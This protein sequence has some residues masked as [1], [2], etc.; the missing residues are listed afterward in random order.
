MSFVSIPRPRRSPLP[1]Q[2]L[3][4]LIGGL[5]LFLMA[6]SLITGGYQLLYAGKVFPGITMAGL[7][8]TNMTP[9]QASSVLSQRLTYPTGGR[10]VFRYQDRVWVATPTE[11]GVVLDTGTSIQRA[12]NV[13]RQG[14]LFNELIS[15]LNAWQGGL[16]LKPVIVFDERVAHGYL[17]NIATQ[18]NQP[19]VETDLHLDGTEVVYT[20]G[21]TGLLLDVDATLASLLPQLSAF[22]DGEVQ[23]AVME[24]SPLVMNAIAPAETLRRI[25]SAP[26]ILNVPDAQPGDPGPWTIDPPHLA[27]ML[28]VGKAQTDAGWQYQVSLDSGLLEQFLGQIA[29][30][31][32]HTPQNARFYFDDNTRELVLV[33]PAVT[34]RALDISATRDAINQ[35][36]L[37]GEHTLPLVLAL[38]QP[39]VGDDD[40]A[41]SLGITSLV[42]SYTSYFRGSG[43]AR[44]QNIDKASD[45]FYG[46]LIPPYATFS[47]GEAM[48]DISL[49]NGYAEALIIYNGKT[50]TG[51]GGGV[52]QVSTTLYR[53]ALYGGYPIVERHEHAYRVYY[54]EQTVSTNS[55]WHLAGLD[56]TVYFPLVDL[57]FTNDRPYW[58][59]METYFHKNTMSLEWKFYSGDDGR[60]SDVQNLGLRNIVPA[61][62]PLFVEDPELAPG[63]CVQKDWPG[64]GADITVTR[65]VSRSGATLFSDNIRTHYEPWQA[66]Y[67]YGPGT[68]NPQALAAQGLCH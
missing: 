42:S 13:G 61:P 1:L 67:N 16:D 8:L 56:A 26:L 44:L 46:L 55:D 24:E 50:I 35:K 15:Q 17:Q 47:M 11:L 54:Y 39:E 20:Q 41:A 2:I 37:Q 57:K 60:T 43:A 58:L 29:P 34:G 12:Y 64:D 3:A 10:I 4:V 65:V 45:Q 18:I 40:T 27:G 49:D 19:V 66:V 28:M 36:L 6:I 51:V 30:L 53:T 32:D 59:L 62:E 63:R 31:M 38:V 21:Q 23:L 14:G 33:Q 25:L 22:R 9:E 48:G 52:C 68:E 7:D 5:L